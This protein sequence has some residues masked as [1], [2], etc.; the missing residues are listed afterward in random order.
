[1]IFLVGFFI[2]GIHGI[3]FVE[4]LARHL[5]SVEAGKGI[6]L[7]LESRFEGILFGIRSGDSDL[8]T[9]SLNV[10]KDVFTAAGV[11]LGHVGQRCELGGEVITS[12][13]SGSKVS[14]DLGAI[15]I[16]IISMSLGGTFFRSSNVNFIELESTG[17]AL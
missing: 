12:D 13:T 15:G 11:S 2:D 3:G 1:M 6:N 10:R 4:P 5:V 17:L 7:E 9:E 16:N 8:G 14:T